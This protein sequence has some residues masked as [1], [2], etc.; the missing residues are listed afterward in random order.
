MK[1]RTDPLLEILRPQVVP[2]RE[3]MLPPVSW[4]PVEAYRAKRVAMGEVGFNRGFRQVPYSDEDRF[5]PNFIKTVNASRQANLSVAGFPRQERLRWES[6]AGVDLSSDS[7]PGTAIFALSVMPDTRKIVRSVRVGKWDSPETAYQ[8]QMVDNMLRPR[9]W[10]VENNG[11]QRALLEWAAAAGPEG[12]LRGGKR[13]PLTFV[14][15]LRPFTTGRNKADPETGLRGMD[16]EFDS[17]AWVIPM[18][19]LPEEDHPETCRCP[20]CRWMYETRLYPH[21]PTTDMVMAA[22]FAWETAIRFSRYLAPAEDDEEPEDRD[23]RGG[24][25]GPSLEDLV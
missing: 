21:A 6:F 1:Q 20:A 24:D 2:E 7:R 12:L 13:I 19:D 18:G 10:A 17:L 22:W 16:I 14:N 8:I 11:Y 25:E 9:I 15:R 4:Y 3:E 5:F 23:R